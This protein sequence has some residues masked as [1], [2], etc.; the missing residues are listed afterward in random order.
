MGVVGIHDY[1]DVVFR[2]GEFANLPQD[3]GQTVAKAVVS[4]VTHNQ[5]RVLGRQLL[6]YFSA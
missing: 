4:A 3:G 5:Q 6:Q 1:R 2:S